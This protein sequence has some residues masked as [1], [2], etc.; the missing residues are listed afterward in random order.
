MGGR[1]NLTFGSGG[2]VSVGGCYITASTTGKCISPQ[3]AEHGVVHI[4]VIY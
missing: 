4:D 3:P 1:T 2:A